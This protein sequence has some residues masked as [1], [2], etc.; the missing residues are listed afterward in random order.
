MCPPP[1]S[2]PVHLMYTPLTWPLPTIRKA[3]AKVNNNKWQCLRN[4]TFSFRRPSGFKISVSLQPVLST[5]WPVASL[6]LISVLLHSKGH[7]EAALAN[8][9]STICPFNPISI[10][11]FLKTF[12]RAC[13][14]NRIL[15][16]AVMWSMVSFVMDHLV[17]MLSS[18]FKY[19]GGIKELATTANFNESSLQM[20]FLKPNSEKVNHLAKMYASV[21]TSAQT[22]AV[23]LRFTRTRDM[24]SLQN[25]EVFFAKTIRV[26][27]VYHG[28]SLDDIFFKLV[29]EIMYCTL[30]HDRSTQPLHRP[31]RLCLADTI[32]SC[33]VE[34]FKQ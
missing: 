31:D 16:G 18:H 30:H 1:R 3:R 21:A 25:I 23:S 17:S 11:G 9:N 29:D 26:R 14:V 2:P 24:T 13:N 7:H 33:H 34:W 5:R 27:K 10:M 20:L 32:P 6:G 12:Q 4:Q 22:D 19:S 15:D 8:G 28:D